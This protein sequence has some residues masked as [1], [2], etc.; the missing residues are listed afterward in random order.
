MAGEAGVSSRAAGFL[1]RLVTTAADVSRFGNAESL[2]PSWVRFLI[3]L[4][5]GCHGFIYLRIGPH[6][7]EMIKDWKG[8]SWL[9]G[10]TV[11]DGRLTA[12]VTALNVLAGIA[13]VACAVAIEL[14]PSL[15]GWWPPLAIAGAMLGIAAF[16]VF[17]DGQTRLLFEEGAIGA[18]VSLV[19]FVS[20]IAFPLAFNR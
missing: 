1:R 12:L 9:L 3:A 4:V 13:T 16:A 6:A 8:T 17:W 18:V 10:S 2:M 11:T 19:L 14:A 20:A 7:A 5:V 15:P